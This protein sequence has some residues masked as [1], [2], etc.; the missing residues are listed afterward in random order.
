MPSSIDRT[1]DRQVRIVNH[2]VIQGIQVDACGL[3]RIMPQCL[4]D[5]RGR[6]V[7]PVGCTGPAMP[8]GVGNH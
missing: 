1:D 6:Y 5:G 8:R 7:Q 2:L 3:F 4:A